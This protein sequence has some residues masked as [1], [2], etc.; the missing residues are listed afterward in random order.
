[1]DKVA[2]FRIQCP[3]NRKNREIF[4]TFEKNFSAT[5]GFLTRCSKPLPCQSAPG[6]VL[7]VYFVLLDSVYVGLNVHVVAKVGKYNANTSLFELDIIS[8]EIR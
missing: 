7:L 5:S 8:M 6:E 1:V 4:K 2:F 3:P